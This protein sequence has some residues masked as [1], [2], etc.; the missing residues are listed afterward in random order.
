MP[1][2]PK[3]KSFVALLY[4]NLYLQEGKS[5]KKV[6]GS[7]VT[8]IVFYIIGC[9]TM[10]YAQAA[11]PHVLNAEEI[12]TLLSGN[13][14]AGTLHTGKFKGR[15]FYN[16]LKPDGTLALRNVL[17]VRDTGI[18]EVTS[19]GKYCRKYKFT[20]GG[21]KLCYEIIKDEEG[22]KLTKDKKTFVIFIMKEGNSENL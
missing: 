4:L 12:R 13:T 5:M 19:D 9:L 20:K 10:P 1:E 3:D 7:V 8:L 15:V 18:W 11:E 17:G 6:L 22:Y 21:R 2:L 16:Y 14:M